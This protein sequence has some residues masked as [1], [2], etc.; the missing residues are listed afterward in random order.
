MTAVRVLRLA[1]AVEV[2][3]ETWR[4]AVKVLNKQGEE[5]AFQLVGHIRGY[6]RFTVNK[7]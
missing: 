6:R 4:V 5:V 2:D 7:N 3:L 1:D